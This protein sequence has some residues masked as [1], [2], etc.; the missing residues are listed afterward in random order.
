MHRVD[1]CIP[2]PLLREDIASRVNLSALGPALQPVIEESLKETGKSKYRKGTILTPLLTVYVVLALAIRRDLSYPAA[3]NWLVSGLRWITCCLPMKLVTDGALSHARKRLGVE[4]FR[5]IFERLRPL[6]EALPM[7]FHGRTSAAFDGSSITMPD[8]ASNQDQF[9]RPNSGRGKGGF[10]Q[11]R[12]MA[13]VILPLRKVADIAYGPFEGKGTGE[14]NL[15]MEIMDRIS[16]SC[17]LFLV[18]AGLYSFDFIQFAQQHGHDVLA[19][20]SASVKPKPIRGKR[21]ADGS[22]L[23]V[24]RKKIEVPERSTA[25]RKAWTTIEI[26]VRIIDYQIPG[27]LPARLITTILDPEI[28]A[29]ELAIHY[30]L[31]WDIEIAFD[32]IKT[33]QCATLRGQAPTI[34]RSKTAELVEQELYA[35]VIVYN[36]VRDLIVQAAEEH[37]NDPTRISFL[38]S[39]HC[40]V[41]AIPTLGAADLEHAQTQ[42]YYLINL[43]AECEIDRPR[44]P[45]VNPRVIKIK[46]SKFERKKD[47]HKSSY[48][49]LENDLQIFHQQAA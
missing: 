32:E 13:L 28:T 10:P 14:R 33:H 22:Y 35:V 30:H 36:C 9:G 37:Q 19:K 21:F 47:F 43:I 31:R 12:L 46:M 27:F 41:E 34:L 25:K 42:Y 4:V 44:R 11:M 40:I 15:M 1:Y 39:L 16:D 17:L 5:R 24:I 20:L 18:D 7:D 48:R 29:K 23:A 3:M 2:R 8:T 49:D 6:A 45:R 38:D 26:V